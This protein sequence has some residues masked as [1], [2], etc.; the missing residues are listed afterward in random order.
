MSKLGD[1]PFDQLVITC[2]F[3]GSGNLVFAFIINDDDDDDDDDDDELFLWYGWPTKTF[4]L[5]SSWGHCQRFL[6][7]GITGTPR[8]GFEPAQDLRSELNELVQWW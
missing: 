3:N 6:S 8:A 2:L 4:S 5:I 1:W 7:L